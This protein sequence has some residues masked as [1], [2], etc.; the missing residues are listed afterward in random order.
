M[1][2]L[3]IIGMG[4]MGKVIFDGLKDA[5]IFE[6]SGV[7]R[8]DNVNAALESVDFFMI[9]VKPQGAAELA[10]EI[11]VD[12]SGKVAISIMAGVSAAKIREL[13]GVKKVARVMPGMPVKYGSGFSGWFADGLEEGEKD[14]VRQ[15]LASFGEEMEVLDETKIDEI[16]ALY[17]SGIAYYYRLNRAFRM[18]ALD[19][20]YSDDDARKIVR[21]TFLGAAELL[22]GSGECS[23]KLISQ[24]ASKG[25]T[26]EAALDHLDEKNFDEIISG[27]VDASIKRAKDLNN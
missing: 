5:G 2:K 18:K 13:F 20:G 3:C 16:T 21:S 17:G 15:S 8:G 23:G 27:A 19:L 6:V 10:N 1:K 26:T 7:G 14:L 12:L 9:A 4:N 11:T 22:K 25:G 24:I